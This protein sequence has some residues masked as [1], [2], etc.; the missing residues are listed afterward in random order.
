MNL[1]PNQREPSIDH[2]ILQ[3]ALDFAI[4][5]LDE[6]GVITAW[7][8]GAEA[9]FGYSAGEIVGKAGDILF[10]PEDRTADA[11]RLEI[12]TA[13]ASGCATDERWHLRKDGRRGFL[14]GSMRPVRNRNEKLLGLDYWLHW[15]QAPSPG[16]SGSRQG[17]AKRE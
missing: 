4:F 2:L 12:E 17:V 8:P 15:N 10:T 6:S 13:L 11:P 14:S 3:S 1:E 9:L 16:S 5:T 7:Y